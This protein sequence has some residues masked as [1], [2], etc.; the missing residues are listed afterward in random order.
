MVLWNGCGPQTEQP[1]ENMCRSY[2]AEPECV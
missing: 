2:L 1:G